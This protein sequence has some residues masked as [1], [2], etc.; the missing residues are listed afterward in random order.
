MR[1]AGHQPD[2][3]PYL[4]FFA[5]MLMVDEFILVD[6]VQY[7]KK[8]W[9]SRNRILGG[10]GPVLLSV[11]V[12]THGRRHQAI[13]AVAIADPAGRWRTKHWRSMVQCYRRAPFFAAHAPFFEAVYQQT[14]TR[15][16]DLNLTLIDY[17]RRCFAIDVP[18]RR[19]RTMGLTAA[20]TGLL[21]QMCQALGADGYLS[22]PGGLFYMDDD[23]MSS[24]GVRSSY[25]DFRHPVYHQRGTPFIPNMSAVDLLFHTGP[26]ARDLLHSSIGRA[27]SRA[28]MMASLGGT[29]DARHA[30]AAGEVPGTNRRLLAAKG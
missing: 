24:A 10:H 19:S 6:H 25:A 9:Q 26:R 28:D 2:H 27:H 13:D 11:P 15:L 5:R 3:L 7:E 29:V 1:I 30:P 21:V 20:K 16:V 8:S 14:W 18:M 12:N 23:E 22:G 4:G 17:L